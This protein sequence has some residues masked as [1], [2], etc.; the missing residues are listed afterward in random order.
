MVGAIL[1]SSSSSSLRLQQGKNCCSTSCSNLG[2]PD[3]FIP[4]KTQTPST[5]QHLHP[6]S[7]SKPALIVRTESNVRKMRRKKPEPSCVDCNGSG[8]VDCHHCHG[9]GRTNLTELMMLPKGEWPKWCKTCGGSGLAYC[10]RCLG[11]GEYRDIMGF[12]FMKREAGL[13]QRPVKSPTEDKPEHLTAADLFLSQ[14]SPE[15]EF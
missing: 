5:Q 9:K 8:R 11:T 3:D 15:S 13:S 7:I 4:R 12:Q 6:L 1:T 10:D 2:N 14:T